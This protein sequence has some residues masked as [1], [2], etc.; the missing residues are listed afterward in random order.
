MILVVFRKKELRSLLGQSV[1]VQVDRPIGYLHKGMVYPV[2]YGF[3]PGMMGGD[4]EYQDAYILGVDV[5]LQTFDGVVI[6]VVCRKNDCEDKL[7]VAPV[8]QRF[9]QG[10]IAE[11]VHFQEQYF[12]TQVLS[13]YKKSCGVIPWR[14]RNGQKEYL[15]LLQN[16]GSWSFPKGHMEAGETEKT[17]ALREL[18]EETG[19]AATLSGP[20]IIMEYEIQPDMRK[21]VVLFPGQ[22]RGTVAL[23]K[24]EITGAKWV[25]REELGRY[26]HPDTFEACRGYLE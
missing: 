1:R 25:R 16:N 22:V 6:G 8:G 9:H 19:L 4:G 14:M 17:T 26:L 3:V 12:D 10:Q 13:M 21:Q 7:V 18:S 24:S 23:Q 11:A 15:V 20:S 2:N 5:P